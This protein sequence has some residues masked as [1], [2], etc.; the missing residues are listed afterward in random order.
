MR[1]IWRKIVVLLRIYYSVSFQDRHSDTEKGVYE[2]DGV[3]PK[4][5]E[6]PESHVECTKGI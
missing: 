4:T 5:E 2:V 3:K 1:I 6:V